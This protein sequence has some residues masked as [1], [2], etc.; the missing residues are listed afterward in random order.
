VPEQVKELG[1]KTKLAVAISKDFADF[2]GYL[3]EVD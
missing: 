1:S 2:K 3:L